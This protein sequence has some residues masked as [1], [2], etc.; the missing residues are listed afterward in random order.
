MDSKL[1]F[2]LP[3]SLWSVLALPLPALPCVGPAIQ[4]LILEE[5]LLGADWLLSH[6]PPSSPFGK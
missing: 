1:P 5:P 4:R 3:F 2:A 6:F